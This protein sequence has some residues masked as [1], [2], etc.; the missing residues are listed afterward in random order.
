MTSRQH[1]NQRSTGGSTGG[2]TRIDR[3]TTQ[4]QVSTKLTSQSINVA[5]GQ[6]GLQGSY[7]KVDASAPR[8]QSV[9][10]PSHPFYLMNHLLKPNQGAKNGRS[11]YGGSFEE[12]EGK[13]LQLD[14]ERKATRNYVLEADH[15]Y[16]EFLSHPA[17]F[18]LTE[19]DEERLQGIEDRIGGFHLGL[20]REVCQFKAG[21]LRQMTTSTLLK[22]S[23]S[24]SPTSSSSTAKKEVRVD[25]KGAKSAAATAAMEA[26]VEVRRLK[27]QLLRTMRALADAF[28]DRVTFFEN[29]D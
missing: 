19:D 29:M 17:L 12:E 18:Y 8:I 2:S 6:Q 22:E 25:S 9:T 26:A 11:G 21:C 16:H 27:L 23:S 24:V 1:W 5:I 3:E 20:L 15:R 14:Q 4:V 28:D 10:L 13:N 7:R